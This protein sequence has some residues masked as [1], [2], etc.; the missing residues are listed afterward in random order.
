MELKEARIKIVIAEQEIAK[1]LNNLEKEVGGT[2]LDI[3]TSIRELTARGKCIP[4]VKIGFKLG[5]TQ[6]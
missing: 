2:I 1:I 5:T 6:L 4:Y 3:D